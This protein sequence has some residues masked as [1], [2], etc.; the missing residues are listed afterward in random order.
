MSGP[1]PG[2]RIEYN[3][4]DRNGQLVAVEG[5]L[6]AHTLR[7]PMRHGQEYGGGWWYAAACRFH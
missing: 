3:R 7:G 5:E 1:A 4:L 6:N 2:A